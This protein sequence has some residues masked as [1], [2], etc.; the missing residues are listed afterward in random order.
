[1]N[2]NFF[3]CGPQ[4]NKSHTHLKQHEREGIGWAISIIM[5][6]NKRCIGLM[7]QCIV[8]NHSQNTCSAAYILNHLKVACFANNGPF[9]L[10]KA[11]ERSSAVY[12]HMEASM[13]SFLTSWQTHGVFIHC[14][15]LH[16][17]VVYWLCEW[18]H[19]TRCNCSGSGGRSDKAIT[20]TSL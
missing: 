14:F 17:S 18:A 3:F 6:I 20:E 9:R 10:T 4:F 15:D 2:R 13:T 7:S 11:Y 19:P 12:F 8:F 16:C 5:H 1:M